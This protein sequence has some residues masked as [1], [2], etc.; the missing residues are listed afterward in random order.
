M[1]N[2]FKI[3]SVFAICVGIAA[4]SSSSS[5]EPEVL[6]DYA[7]QYATD[8][9]S[10]D[11]YID[12]HYLTFDSEYNVTFDTLLPSSGHSSIR[13]DSAFQLKDTTVT[14]DG[15]NYKIYFIKFREGTK[16]RPTQVDSVH[17]S[18]KGIKLLKSTTFDQ[19]VTPT[20]F[21]LQ[22]VITGWSHILPNFHT[23]TYTPGTGGNPTTF[24]NYG[25]GVMFLPS[26]LAYFNF[27]AG[28]IPTYSPIIFSFKLHEL[29]YR[30]QDGDG[31]LS[32]DER[33]LDPTISPLIRWKENPADNLYKKDNTGAVV[34]DV[35]FLDTDG[36]GYAN[37]YDIDDDGDHVMTR[38]EIK[39]P[40]GGL[41]L[42]NMIPDCSGTATN[43]NRVRK[44]IDPACH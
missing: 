8:L 15:I 44:H 17:V 26:G 19:A 2:I 27:S 5:T 39:N 7:T 35:P 20:W 21:R 22:E 28:T 3:L 36:D 34:T 14:E 40:S 42:Y 6:R 23:G 29:R 24:D 13:T 30:D 37:M 43:P 25:A 16:D 33:K 31:V 41:Y 32:K 9:A 10:I 11:T 38:I 18:Y 4:C 1:N 12:T